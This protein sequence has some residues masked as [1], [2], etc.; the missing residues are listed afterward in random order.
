M[1][2][3]A[4]H[5]TWKDEGDVARP[6]AARPARSDFFAKEH[7]NMKLQDF[8]SQTLEEIIAGVTSAQAS[9]KTRGACINPS[10]TIIR[11][12]EV[13]F[14]V[15]VTTTEGTQTEGGVGIFVGLVG[16][17]SRGQSDSTN[18]SMTRIKFSVPVQLPPGKE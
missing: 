12:Q 6:G 11:L 14:D 1:V 15:A 5:Q 8:V 9:A 10:D 7:V 3:A 2:V 16:P 4:G 13:E 17:G 18:Q